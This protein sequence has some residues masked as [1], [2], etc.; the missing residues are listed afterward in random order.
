[1][2]LSPVVDCF[3]GL[4]LT[5]NIGTTPDSTLVNTMLYDAVGMFSKNER[6]LVHTDRGCHVRQ[7]VA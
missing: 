7:E 4:I 2:F 1:V 5:W 3:D 6:P